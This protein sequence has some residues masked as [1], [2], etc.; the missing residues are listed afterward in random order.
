[1]LLKYQDNLEKCCSDVSI[2]DWLITDRESAELIWREFICIRNQL[3][4]FGWKIHISLQ[5]AEK[6]NIFSSLLPYLFENKISFKI[7]KREEDYFLI[8]SGEIGE[9]QI[10][11]TIT[12]YPHEQH[13]IIQLLKDLN[14][15]SKDLF[16]GPIVKYDFRVDF[17]SPVYYR[18]GTFALSKYSLDVFGRPKTFVENHLGQKI[19]DDRASFFEN[20]KQLKLPVENPIH[21]DAFN[22]SET[23]NGKYLLLKSIYTSSKK[24]IFLGINLDSL[25]NIVIKRFI[26]RIQVDLNGT[27][28]EDLAQNE[29]DAIKSLNSNTDVAEKAF[30]LIKR[31]DDTLLIIEDIPG[32]TIVKLDYEKQIKLIDDVFSALQKIHHHGFIH[33]DF[34]PS[35]ILL[36]EDRIKIIDWENAGK[37][38][39]PF[40]TNSGTS[41]YL[42]NKDKFQN[43]NAL[44]DYY[45][46]VSYLVSIALKYDVSYLP[47]NLDFIKNAL[48][49]FNYPKLS[50]LVLKL[51]SISSVNEYD[52]DEIKN[53][54]QNC[55]SELK[56]N[57]LISSES[58]FNTA[59]NEKGLI[60][61]TLL[62]I[63]RFY[64][65]KENKTYWRNNHLFPDF[66]LEG[67]NL[68]SS[69]IIIGLLSLEYLSDNS[70]KF[71]NLITSSA[72]GLCNENISKDSNGLF[73]GNAGAALALACCYKKFGTKIF[74]DECIKRLTVATNN[75]I[76]A[77]LFSG[78]AGVAYSGV[79]ISE[80]LNDKF[81]LDLINPAI[82]WLLQNIKCLDDITYWETSGVLE[83]DKKPFVGVAHGLIGIAFALEKYNEINPNNDIDNVTFNCLD[84]SINNLFDNEAKTIKRYVTGSNELSNS[85]HWCHGVVGYL[86]AVSQL[87]NTANLST[88]S[89]SFAEIVTNRTGFMNPTIC[90]GVAGVLET[91]RLMKNTNF[92]NIEILNKEEDKYCSV[93]NSLIQNVS[94]TRIWSSE[95]P[96]KFTPDLWVG[97]L[98]SIVS[99]LISRRN[100]N[101]AIISK[102]W[103]TR[104]TTL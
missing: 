31:S 85:M 87:K 99:L 45:A 86:W 70:G 95:N 3:P 66:N 25:D 18:F 34:K 13:H 67:I 29:F 38:G 8:N 80:I 75:F 92:M 23:I 47:D 59:N 82:E 93:L 78:A 89:S 30:E 73:T 57:H 26:N 56:N 2:I 52:L 43:N 91:I 96:K 17:N 60:D 19:E 10:G 94:N 88:I 65:R 101:E 9:T 5:S 74:L 22:P 4:N 102:E 27:L 40:I 16:N 6:N 20:S 50:L 35:N 62:F 71:E 90:H 103:L 21:G 42:I 84:K 1:M 36:I 33:G 61:E 68:G 44:F 64:I 49:N 76:E 100:I 46:F 53:E 55:I 48:D 72:F 81:F 7:P 41:G 97:H 24:Q 104:I 51:R 79:L 39:T 63:N 77:D 11:K 58:I 12:I 54:I 98:G 15:M 83:N 28:N 37:I 69:G 32:T 14:E